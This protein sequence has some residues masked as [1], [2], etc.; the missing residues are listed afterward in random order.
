MTRQEQQDYLIN[1]SKDTGLSPLDRGFA[2]GD[3]VFRTLIVD[4][5]TPRHWHLHYAKLLNDCSAMAIDC[6]PDAI[7]LEDIRTL[8]ADNTGQAVAKIVITR[9]IGNRGYAIPAVPHPNRIVIRAPFPVLPPEHFEQ[10]I[11]LHVCKLRLGFQPRLAGIKHLNRLENVL[12]RA[13][14]T[15]NR[16]ADGLL[17]DTE[18][19]AIECTMS[20]L[21]VRF[22]D[23]LLTPDLSRCGVAGVTR[24]RILDLAAGM[25]YRTDIAEIPFRRLMDADEILVCNSLFGVLQVRKIEQRQW[26]QQATAARLRSLLLE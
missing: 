2:Y 6:P 20:N 9:G 21:F 26:P 1:G 23:T 14:W 12:A 17:L 5:S 8:F 4:G 7:L 11:C 19:N 15:D 3:G 25:G 13:E 22:G 16:F 10:G 24:Q 18:G